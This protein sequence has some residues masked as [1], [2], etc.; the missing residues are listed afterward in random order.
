[1]H[2]TRLGSASAALALVCACSATA[3]PADATDDGEIEA[4]A[5]AL[6]SSPLTQGE[7]VRFAA[8][9]GLPTPWPQPDST[10]LF[11]ERG[12]CGPTAVSNLLRLYGTDLSPADADRSGVHWWIGTR[13]IT[14]RDWL[15]EK[16]PRLGCTLEHP[17]DGPGF[18]RDHLG[19]GQPVLLWFNTAGGY[20]SHWVTA[21]GITGAGAGERVVVMSW[22]RYYTIAMDKLDAAWRNV[23]WIRR[24]SIVCDAQT[25][26]MP[27]R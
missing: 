23:Y 14:I 9:A 18:L 15:T 4:T 1:M 2:L 5:D 21:V 10:G 24:P 19:R 12:K 8:P 27:A 25:T 13:G 17:H 20:N 16:H 22:G 6:Q 11:D 7:M 3:A 26:L